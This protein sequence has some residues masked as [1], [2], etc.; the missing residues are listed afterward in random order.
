M[1]E[2]AGTMEYRLAPAH[3]ERK[4]RELELADAVFVPSN[5]VAR[6]LEGFLPPTK[7]VYVIP[8]GSPNAPADAPVAERSREGPLRVLFAGSMTQRKGLAD[9]FAAMKL[10][11]RKDVELRVLGSPQQ[12]LSFY[13]SRGD[14]THLPP[15]PHA[16]VLAAMR[17]CDVFVLPSIVEGRA[18]VQQE[19]L[20]CG[21]P[22]IVTANAGGEDL[23][24]EGRT[25]FLV[26][27]R[28]PAAIADRI[29]WFVDHRGELP[30]MREAAVA[31][32]REH[33][34]EAYGQAIA[35]ILRAGDDAREAAGT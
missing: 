28:E 26:P 13:H 21:L 7:P 1:P 11:N 23:V 10:L 17:D 34:W 29:Q 4:D 18:L 30:A 6:S 24:E 2:W 35:R 19:A 22:I 14:F 15:R 3:Y 12:P 9:V 32:A 8:F 33:P 31:K 27:I 20:A 16:E 25:G 5:F